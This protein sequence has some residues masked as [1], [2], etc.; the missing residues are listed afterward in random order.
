MSSFNEIIHSEK[1]VLVDFFAEW[2]GPCKAM[3]PVLKEVALKLKDNARVLKIDVDKNP[4]AASHFNIRSVPTLMI[5]R[6]GA[7]VWQRPGVCSEKEL[8]ETLQQFM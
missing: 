5:F 4:K 3:A 7:V 6:K 2:C 8:I 1:P